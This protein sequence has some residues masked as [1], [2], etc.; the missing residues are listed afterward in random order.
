MCQPMMKRELNDV[1]FFQDSLTSLWLCVAF[2]GGRSLCLFPGNLEE[3][4]RGDQPMPHHVCCT[5]Q[6]AHSGR[7]TEFIEE[8]LANDALS[9]AKWAIK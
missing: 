8:A 7:H 3:E 2:Q 4:G 1:G 9:D 5:G 6:A